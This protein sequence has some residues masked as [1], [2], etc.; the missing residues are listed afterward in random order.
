[1]S[2]K[3][4]PGIDRA[5]GLS[6]AARTYWQNFDNLLLEDDVLYLQWLGNDARPCALRL[7]AP[8][9]LQ[10]KVLKT[11]HDT[12]FA[13]HMGVG[14]TVDQVKHRF[15]W[16]GLCKDVKLHIRCCKVG[17]ANRM[18]YWRFRTALA[19]FRVGAPLD[20]ISVDLMGALPMTDQGNRYLLV[21]VDYFTRWAE[22]FSLPDQQAETMARTLVLEL[23]ADMVP[24]WSCTPIKDEILT[25]FSSK[26]CAACLRLSRRGLLCIIPAATGSWR[27]STKHWDRS[28]GT[29]LKAVL[30]IGTS[31]SLC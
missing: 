30:V 1:M 27:D 7:L 22:A 23:C 29:I 25:A 16:P 28:Y 19:N 21:I 2:A 4:R 15:H 3:E 17:N 26:R 11:C 24:H 10:P 14:R 9:S 5:A 18:P 20:R 6:P 8:R 12:L 31:S 13:A